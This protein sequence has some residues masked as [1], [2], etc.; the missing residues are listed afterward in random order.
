MS[1]MRTWWLMAAASCC[2]IGPAVAQPGRPA[3]LRDKGDK[4]VTS[5]KVILVGHRGAS[6]AA[7]EN[8]L[9]AFRLAFEEGA[10]FIEG[11]FWSTRDERIVCLHDE[12]TRR[13][14][15]QQPLRTVKD[16]TLA[17]LRE[18]DVGAWK[19]AK[20]AHTRI[21]TLEEVLATVP[22]DKG[23]YLEI[24]DDR[25]QIAK[26]LKRV[27]DRSALE[28]RQIAIIAFDPAIIQAVKAELPR[29]KAHWLYWWYWDKE[30]D[31][32]SNTASEIIH[33][34]RAIHADGL[35]VNKCPWAN[36]DFI[37]QVRHAGLEFHVYTINELV[38]AARYVALEA[39]SITTDRPQGL[40]RQLE[41]YF[42]PLESTSDVD[43]VL[44]VNP[45]GTWTFT[46]HR[47]KKK[48]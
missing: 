33:V 14:A 38:D 8:T 5:E 17:E 34:A 47:P 45:D 21:P 19:D 40:R 46:P 10:D 43:E 37:R 28:P 4:T 20:Y 7:P 36:A 39:D 23:I 42:K 2:G 9:P 44:T 15:P 13:V 11:D 1:N 12:D 30:A 32:L 48:K 27:L 3:P 25:P 29:I 22:K 16:S 6:H 18:L 24:K 26:H 41:D 31:K 35:D